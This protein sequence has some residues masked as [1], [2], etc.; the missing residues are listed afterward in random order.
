M[1]PPTPP[2]HRPPHRF[3]RALSARLAALALG[4][5]ALPVAELALRSSAY[6]PLSREEWARAHGVLQI[7]HL[8]DPT[9]RLID[10]Q[11]GGLCRPAPELTAR[12]GQHGGGME[13]D[14]FPCAKAQGTLRV[15]AVGASSV[16]GFGLRTGQSWPAQLEQQRAAAGRPIEVINAGVN[17]AT[18]L[19]LRR[20]APEL[21]QLRPDL[22]LIYAGHNDFNYYPVLAAALAARPEL[23][24]ARAWGDRLALLRATRAGLRWAGLLPPPPPPATAERIE[25]RAKTLAHG[26]Q[27][28]FRSPE[29]LAERRAAQVRAA[30]HIEAI[31]D[32]NIT[33]IVV[34]AKAAGARVA[35]LTPLNA[36]SEPHLQWE[37]SRPLSLDEQARFIALWTALREAGPAGDPALE[38][39]L[40]ALDPMHA[41]ALS[42][43]GRARLRRGDRI[44]AADALHAAQ[45]ALPTG[46]ALRAPWPFGDH[47][48]AL[49]DRLGVLGIDLRPTFAE[50]ALDEGALFFDQVHF[51][52]NGAEQVAAEVGRQ[53]EA[54]GL[55]GPAAR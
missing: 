54:G 50:A 41:G 33:D 43:I 14:T 5:G 52:A 19:Q 8:I 42:D 53:L 31:F 15:L 11:P 6:A 24:R 28:P 40:L 55:L 30:A 44:G 49:A 9:G 47:V 20:A 13:A 27:A 3:G 17:G 22:V 18:T 37:H 45:A 35:L 34:Q 1:Q 4:L 46:R 26:R 21:L 48:M 36:L 32:E 16:R 2:N 7:E 39:A 10:K 38:A 12:D 23:L 29:E 51:H 25:P